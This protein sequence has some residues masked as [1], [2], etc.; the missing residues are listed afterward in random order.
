MTTWRRIGISG[1]LTGVVGLAILLP[2]C[3]GGGGAGTT[4]G[5]NAEVK[6]EPPKDAQGKEIRIEDEKPLPTK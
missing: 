4:T 6:I 1:I 2:G 5:P 3:G